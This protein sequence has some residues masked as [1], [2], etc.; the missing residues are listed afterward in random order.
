MEKWTCFF[1]LLLL[2]SLKKQCVS[3]RNT[4]EVDE[5]VKTIRIIK[6]GGLCK[7]ETNWLVA[8]ET[9]MFW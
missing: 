6:T 2:K 9:E 1:T 8:Y 7:R 5:F 4:F 3:C